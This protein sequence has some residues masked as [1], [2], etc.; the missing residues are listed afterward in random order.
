MNK[1]LIIYVIGL[2]GLAGLFGHTLKLY[3]IWMTAF[4]TGND[5]TV[6]INNYN[7]ATPEFIFFPLTVT[8]GLIGLYCY[9]KMMIK[10][11]KRS[12]I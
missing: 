6:A 1:Q 11:K 8:L 12:V 3:L 4:I 10:E 2:I 5:V 7:E 9:F